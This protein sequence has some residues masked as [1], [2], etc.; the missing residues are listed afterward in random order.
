MFC[1]T[2][3]PKIFSLSRKWNF[4]NWHLNEWIISCQTLDIVKTNFH[5]MNAVCQWWSCNRLHYLQGLRGIYSATSH[6]QPTCQRIK[7]IASYFEKGI[8]APKR[9]S[10]PPP[11]P[12][13]PTAMYI[14]PANKSTDGLFQ[15]WKKISPLRV[16]K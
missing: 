16:R 6:M 15:Q 1:L 13:A 10:H 7:V 8:S 2:N 14:R 11:P 4:Q 3:S 12:R 5:I 9:K